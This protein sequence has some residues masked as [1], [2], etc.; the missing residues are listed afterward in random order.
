MWYAARRRL[1]PS[2][3]AS[4]AA[5]IPTVTKDSRAAVGTSDVDL[6]WK[7]GVADARSGALLRAAVGRQHALEPIRY[8]AGG[9]HVNSS[10]ALLD[11]RCSAHPTQA[12]MQHARERAHAAMLHAGAQTFDMIAQPSNSKEFLLAHDGTARLARE[13]NTPL[14]SMLKHSRKIALQ[15]KPRNRNP[16]MQRIVHEPTSLLVCFE[17][18]CKS[19]APMQ[20][21][22]G[23]AARLARE[24]KDAA[25]VHAEPADKGA[26]RLARERRRRRGPVHVEAGHDAGVLDVPEARDAA[27]HLE[28]RAEL[29]LEL[30][31]LAAADAGGGVEARE[32]REACECVEGRVR[33]QCS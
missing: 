13:Q 9:T 29:R 15:Q 31:K 21:T 12:P 14:R 4:P 18:Q 11:A 2:C 22:A 25:L 1:R 26:E 32:R 17:T 23:A 16:M 27:Q 10:S 24:H 20:H 7:L 3:R 19:R 30:R 6:G 28:R 33:R 8:I 5:T